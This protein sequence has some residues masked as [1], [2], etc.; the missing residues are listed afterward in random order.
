M[1]NIFYLKLVQSRTLIVCI[2]SSIS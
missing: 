1:Y 2:H